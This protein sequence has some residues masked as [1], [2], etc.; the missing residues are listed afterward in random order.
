VKGAVQDPAELAA[1]LFV[2]FS[3]ASLAQLWSAS[4]RSVTLRPSNPIVLLQ[5]AAF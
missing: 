3:L 1:M 5:G 4:D 2:I